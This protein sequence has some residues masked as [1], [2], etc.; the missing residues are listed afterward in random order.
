MKNVWIFGIVLLIIS[1]EYKPEG[2]FYHEVTPPEAEALFE[3]QLNQ[4]QPLNTIFLFGITQ[5]TLHLNT[6][7]KELY[8]LKI[9]MDGRTLELYSIYGV[10]G[11]YGF[12]INPW[13]FSNGDH[14]LS[15]SIVTASGSGS[16]ADMMGMEGYQGE[17]SW[18]VY[19]INDLEDKFNINYRK[20]EDDMLEFRWEMQN[21][22]ETI[23][24]KYEIQVGMKHLNITDQ[25][26]KSFIVED[27]VCG[28]IQ[29]HITVFL[30]SYDGYIQH[31]NKYL[32]FTSPV[33]KLYFKDI[34]IDK[35][36][37]YWDKPFSKARFSL[38]QDW[39]SHE[40]ILTTDTFLIV[41]QVPFSGGITFYLIIYPDKLQ[42]LDSY[43][44]TYGGHSISS[45][46]TYAL[47]IAYHT[48]MGKI[49]AISNDQ[50]WTINSTTFNET[51]QAKLP[52]SSFR[53]LSCVP[54]SS[55]IAIRHGSELW[56][57]PDH[58][59]TNPVIVPNKWDWYPVFFQL[60]NNDR[61]FIIDISYGTEDIC[62]VYD[63]TDGSVIFSFNIRPFNSIWSVSSDGKYFCE[64]TRNGMT[65]H[66]IGAS[67][68]EQ[69]VQVP[70][71]YTNA[72]FN[73]LNPD[74]LVVK[75]RDNI[76]IFES[77]DFTNPVHSF[78][79][80]SSANL[81]NID[82]ATG[83]L[84]YL[85]QYPNRDTLRVARPEMVNKPFF[86]IATSYPEVVLLDNCLINIYGA[87]I[88]NISQYLKP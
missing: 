66:Q 43:D 17:I 70:G 33:P 86:S 81:L 73:P 72:M 26:Q 69:T 45:R 60:T 20:T 35:L 39:F 30:K 74:Q 27:Y 64:A 42:V 11:N 80:P 47:N 67:D 83:Y 7:G 88:F 52:Y 63:V 38:S 9:S 8:E 55:K 29:F 16:L 23:F 10:P 34:S 32:N 57:Y 41:P 19:T 25:R 37:I 78:V 36:L 53:L 4:I 22:P 1:C 6:Y 12:M 65:I 77:S 79:I 51:I 14:K 68:I 18:N 62:N 40:G 76:Q 2:D 31:F 71:Y 58:T 59:F 15:V 84:L 56:I 87:Q 21:I 49:L 24:E 75:E 50:A 13:E 61:I 46:F 82:P 44:S 3:I 28:D 54:G 85:Q 5:L 48:T